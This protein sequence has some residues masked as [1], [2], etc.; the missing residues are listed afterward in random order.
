MNPKE[1]YDTQNC[2]KPFG[3]CHIGTVLTMA[4]LITSASLELAYMGVLDD[5]LDTQKYQSLQLLTNFAIAQHVQGACSPM[6]LFNIGLKDLTENTRAS[7]LYDGT[8]VQFSHTPSIVIGFV[9]AL[10]IVPVYFELYRLMTRTQLQLYDQDPDYHRAAQQNQ[11]Y[12]QEEKKEKKKEGPD[13]SGDPMLSQL[14]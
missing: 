13:V 5:V 10:I 7:E 11:V 12:Q 6:E 2:V 8:K 1:K 3:G 14:Q 9:Y 4:F